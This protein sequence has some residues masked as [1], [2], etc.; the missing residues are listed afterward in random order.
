MHAEGHTMRIRYSILF[1]ASFLVLTGCEKQKPSCSSE[2]TQKLLGQTLK[3]LARLNDE[4]RDASRINTEI[5]KIHIVIE[6]IRTTREDPNG[7]KVFCTGNLKI[8][9]DVDRFAGMKEHIDGSDPLQYFRQHGIDISTGVFSKGI[10]YDVPQTVDGELKF[11]YIQSW[12]LLAELLS[13]IARVSLQ[14]SRFIASNDGTVLDEKTNLMWAAKDNGS[15]IDW[16]GARSYCD[17][18]RGGGYKDWR[19]PT[20]AELAELYYYALKQSNGN[21]LTKL[22]EITGEYMWA[23]ETL[24]NNSAAVYDFRHD[25]GTFIDKQSRVKKPRAIPVRSAKK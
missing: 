12:K 18:Y 6:G 7:T 21:Y 17:N 20:Q 1:L 8:N 14:Q 11:S 9:F 16:Q 3:R 15:P 2:N 22:I 13:T 25:L 19:M 10:V 24:G 23:S 5:E 4:A